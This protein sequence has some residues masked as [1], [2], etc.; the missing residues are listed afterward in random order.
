MHREGRCVCRWR[1]CCSLWVCMALL[2]DTVGARTRTPLQDTVEL[3][4]IRVVINLS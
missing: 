3:S 2:R 1:R 4:C